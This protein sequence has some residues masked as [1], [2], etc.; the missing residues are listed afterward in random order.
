MMTY[1]VQRVYCL[2]SIKAQAFD[3][4]RHSERLD[5]QAKVR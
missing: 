4:K 3:K 5:L 1:Y 2:A